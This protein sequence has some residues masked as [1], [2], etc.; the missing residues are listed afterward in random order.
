MKIPTKEECYQLLKENNVPPNV[1][2]HSEAV[3][4]VS[5]QIYN[6]IKTTHKLNPDILV[7]TA[8]LHD[9]EKL[10]PNHV[11]AGEEFLRSKKFHELGEFVGEHGIRKLPKSLYG[12]ILFYA[13]KRVI[14]N[15]I[16]S[17]EKRVQ[18]I[19]DKYNLPDQAKNELINTAK[20]IEKELNINP[21]NIK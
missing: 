19:E 17:F 14:E 5:L 4:N 9:I 12:K 10:K 13:D 20:S 1:I 21:N 18:Y 7:T 15:E 16:V 3:A 8:L 6:Q 11:E 2:A